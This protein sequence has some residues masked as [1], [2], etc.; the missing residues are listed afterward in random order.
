MLKIR[1]QIAQ[2][3]VAATCTAFAV[4][5]LLYGHVLTAACFALVGLAAAALDWSALAGY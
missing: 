2:V 4:A 3:A 1:I 5:F